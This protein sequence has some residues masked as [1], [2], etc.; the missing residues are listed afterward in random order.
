MSRDDLIPSEQRIHGWIAEVFSRGSRRPGYPADR[1]AEHWIARADHARGDPH[2]R[3]DA[4]RVGRGHAGR[5]AVRSRLGTD[6]LRKRGAA[7]ARSRA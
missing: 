6:R 4:G 1:W 7:A 2:H 5:V 3:V